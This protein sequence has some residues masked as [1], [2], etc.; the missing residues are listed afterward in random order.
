M[1][2]VTPIYLALAVVIYSILAFKVI[3]DRRNQKVS[4]GDGGHSDLA[5]KIRSHG[6]FA[7]YVPLAIIALGCAEITNVSH[8][9]IHLFGAML[10]LGR[11]LH[12][13][14]FL[15]APGVMKIRVAGMILTFFAMWGASGTALWSVIAKTT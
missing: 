13:F 15:A 8:A 14:Y 3:G 9:F 5:H 1:L 7:E 12:A 10:I 11:C 4:I 2:A 6:N